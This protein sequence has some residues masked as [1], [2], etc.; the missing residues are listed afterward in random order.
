MRRFLLLIIVLLLIP[1]VTALD[2]DVEFYRY[3][4]PLQYVSTNGQIVVDILFK[5]TGDDFTSFNADISDIHKNQY[6]VQTL[7]YQDKAMAKNQC[8]KTTDGWDCWLRDLKMMPASADVKIVIHLHGNETIEVNKTVSF[9]VDDTRPTLVSLMPE[10]CT[11]QPC[12]IP[13]S[14]PFKIVAN[15]QDTVGDFSRGNVQYSIG[16]QAGVPYNCSGMTC[17]GTGFVNCNTGDMLSLT[18]SPSL[19]YDSAGNRV[20]NTNST[21]LECDANAPKFHNITIE[22]QEG[23]NVIRNQ[24]SIGVTALIEDD[25]DTAPSAKADLTNL[26]IAAGDWQECIRSGDYWKCVFEGQVNVGS[27]GEQTYKVMAKDVVGNI[28]NDSTGE[29]TV[30]V[31][32]L[33]ENVKP[34]FWKVSEVQVTPNKMSKKHM[35]FPRTAYVN[36]KL[37]PKKGNPK[38]LSIGDVSAASCTAIEGKGVRKVR[39]MNQVPGVDELFFEVQLEQGPYKNVST[40]KYNCTFQTISKSGLYAAKNYEDDVFEFE[41]HL[42][43]LESMNDLLQKEINSSRES[44]SKLQEF[45]SSVASFVRPFYITCQAVTKIK[46]AAGILGTAQSATSWMSGMTALGLSA[47]PNTMG[48]ASDGLHKVADNAF[49]Q[50][51]MPA[52]E[53][54]TCQKQSKILDKIGDFGGLN[55][56]AQ[57]AGY[58]S[59]KDAL[60]PNENIAASALTFCLPG[61]LMNLQ[62]YNTIQCSYTQCLSQQV[63]LLGGDISDCQRSK[64]YSTCLYVTGGVFDAIPWTAM[65]KAIGNTVKRVL[66]DPVTFFSTGVAGIACG[67]FV[68]TPVTE[69]NLLHGI[70]N[71]VAS[72]KSIVEVYGMVE[73][74]KQPLQ[75]DIGSD[76]CDEI[77][78]AVDPKT[79]QW[80]GKPYDPK[81]L[82]TSERYDPDDGKKKYG[83]KS[84]DCDLTKGCQVDNE[85][86]YIRVVGLKPGN[87]IAD[88]PENIQFYSPKGEYIGTYTDVQRMLY[89]HYEAHKDSI[90]SQLNGKGDGSGPTWSKG[91]QDTLNKMKDPNGGITSPTDLNFIDPATTVDGQPETTVLPGTSGSATSG[92]SGT[93]D[94]SLDQIETLSE[95][96]FLTDD[97]NFNWKSL[98][99]INTQAKLAAN[100]NAK[101]LAEAKKMDGPTAKRVAE[102]YK[103]IDRHNKA[104]GKIRT[105]EA[106]S[107]QRTSIIDAAHD[108]TSEKDFDQ[109][110]YNAYI[111]DPVPYERADGVGER[112]LSLDSETIQKFDELYSLQTKYNGLALDPGN[113]VDLASLNNKETYEKARKDEAKTSDKI[114]DDK[115]AEQDAYD[116]KLKEAQATADFT[117]AWDSGFMHAWASAM[118]FGRAMSLVADLFGY[119]SDTAWS[120]WMEENIFSSAVFKT[121]ATP[122]EAFCE[123]TFNIAGA[124]PSAP[125]VK[126]GSINYQNAAHV[127]AVKN[128]LET[129]NGSKYEYIIT[130]GV[131]S[132][133]KDGLKFKLYLDS[134]D[135]TANIP[136]GGKPEIEVA[137]NAPVKFSGSEDITIESTTNYDEV[138]IKFLNRD[139]N[140]YFDDVTA[141]DSDHKLCQK[142]ASE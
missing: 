76:Q 7:G 64:S 12:K 139:L 60:N 25:N 21:Q 98:Q 126:V 141:L 74:L 118:N 93:P 3:G 124:T 68:P 105:Q 10:G 20:Q 66:T 115:E 52:C 13:A 79:G 106:A 130:G 26:G 80:L 24:D 45:T 6:V 103:D 131:A 95:A 63:G 142:I 73:S 40:I 137:S 56:M 71:S 107:N 85:G 47:I 65:T 101:V 114:K 84:Y 102:F 81:T 44:S 94:L 53:Y 78:A 128:Q 27:P 50:Y 75:F 19:T 82:Q 113:T 108:I 22:S 59:F 90:S 5:V 41:I 97:G 140:N 100:H 9:T 96:G 38:I 119:S 88:H 49:V 109:D 135:I 28:V 69:T 14:T 132:Q 1:T 86:A 42:D 120:N 87:T 23:F 2:S 104:M 117:A 37:T 99:K 15:F 70:C 83:F 18:I 62:R 31:Y 121:L 57:L 111:N 138:C 77:M 55:K 4:Q 136:P 51:I 123:D 116:S 110:L 39:L 112:L 46:Q 127:E 92:G 17:Y 91:Q 34:D 8:T 35:L 54:L 29:K 11:E 129:V 58:N 133:K 125:A 30:M 67:I 36:V 43:T 122:S 72:A 134:K 33:D 48:L 32:G 61:M 16:G 89:T